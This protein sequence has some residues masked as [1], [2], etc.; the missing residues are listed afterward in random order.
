MCYRFPSPVWLV[1]QRTPPPAPAPPP[2]YADG[3]GA[4]ARF[5]YPV[6][7]ACLSRQPHNV[8]V[9]DYSNHRIRLVSVGKGRAIV[10]GGNGGGEGAVVSTLAG[11]VQGFDDGPLESCKFVG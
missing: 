7:I 11:S 1:W 4:A 10:A 3:V 6:G 2:G 8:V 9:A 5:N